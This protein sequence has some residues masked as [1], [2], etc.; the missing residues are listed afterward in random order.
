[1]TE[2][3]KSMMIKMYSLPGKDPKISHA[4]SCQG[5]VGKTTLCLGSGLLGFPVA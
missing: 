5:P 2:I 4:Q 3:I 1:M